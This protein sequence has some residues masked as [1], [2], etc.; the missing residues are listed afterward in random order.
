MP[1]TNIYVRR[2][3]LSAFTCETEATHPT[4]LLYDSRDDYFLRIMPDPFQS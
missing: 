1:M 4:D 3:A 2:L